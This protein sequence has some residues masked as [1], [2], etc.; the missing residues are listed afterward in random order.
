MPTDER[1]ADRRRSALARL[2]GRAA[3]PLQ[4]AD[5]RLGPGLGRAD[6]PAVARR[7]ESPSRTRPACAYDPDCYLCPGNTRANGN[8]NPDYPETFVFTNDFA[9]L[10][11]GHVRSTAFDDGLLRAEGERGSCR[12]VCFSPRHD[13]TL[14]RMAP[15]AVR[16][17]HRRVGRADRR[18]GRRRTAGSRCSRTA[19]RRWAPRTRIR[20]ARSGPAR[21]CPATAAREDAAQRAHLGATGRR[22]LLDYVDQ[23]SGGPAGRRRD[24]RLAD[25]RA[26]LG[27]LAVRDAARAASGR[28]RA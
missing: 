8:V 24:R 7:R 6:P 19:A 10:R 14:G 23:E 11:P 21:R 27:G 17:G 2:A 20:T 15:D 26:V 3:S 4:P 28:P 18:A 22:L 25:R 16:R 9:A 5:R 13:L 1:S 12:V